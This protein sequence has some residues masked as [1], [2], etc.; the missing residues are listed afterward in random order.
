MFQS[1]RALEER[2]DARYLWLLRFSGVGRVQLLEH[3]LV[4]GL[5]RL[6]LVD[7]VHLRLPAAEHQDH[8]ARLNP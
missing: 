6:L 5:D 8:G 1:S 4:L 2:G 3:A 7:V